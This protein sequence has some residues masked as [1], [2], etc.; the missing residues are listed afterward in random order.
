MQVYIVRAFLEFL[1]AEKAY[2]AEKHYSM[3]V[4]GVVVGLSVIYYWTWGRRQYAGPL[5]EHQV[6]NVARKAR[7]GELDV[8]KRGWD[9]NLKEHRFVGTFCRTLLF[10][11][12]PITTTRTTIIS[13][14]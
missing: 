1:A 3:L 10:S 14:L 7:E 5:I 2:H 13:I 12:P 11:S 4:T 8:L 6:R 9:R